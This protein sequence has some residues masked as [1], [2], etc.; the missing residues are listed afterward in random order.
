MYSEAMTGEKDGWVDTAV[1]VVAV[2]LGLVQIAL[3]VDRATDGKAW[4]SMQAGWTR[5]WSRWR[6]LREVDERVAREAGSVIW[7]ATGIVE[8]V[9]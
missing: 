6:R 8:D 7:E 4:S 5:A 1:A 2:A 3:I 9:G